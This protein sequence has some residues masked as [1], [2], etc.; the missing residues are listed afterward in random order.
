MERKKFIIFSEVLGIAIFLLIFAQGCGK[1]IYHPPEKGTNSNIILINEI[2]PP[3][4]YVEL[5]GQQAGFLQQELEIKVKPGPHKL[6]IFNKETALSLL[7][8]KQ[9]TVI[10]KFNFNLKVE[11][12]ETKKIV[13]SWEDKEYS[14]EV[15]KG[16]SPLDKE[17]EEKQRR[18]RQIEGP[19]S[20]P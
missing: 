18:K 12:G 19:S 3:G 17:K 6:K 2:Y 7:K 14:K 5:D 8:E 10:H 9:E 13:L 11:D 15:R 20:L 1:K 4:F 16:I